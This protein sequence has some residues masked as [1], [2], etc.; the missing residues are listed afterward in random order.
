MVKY[1]VW[2]NESARFCTVG[3]EI[4]GFIRAL[5]EYAPAVS[6]GLDRVAAALSHWI[7]HFLASDDDDDSR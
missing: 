2:A 3:A 5:A 6:H 7:P 1:R 4:R